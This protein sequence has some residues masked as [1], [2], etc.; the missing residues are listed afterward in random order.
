MKRETL[1]YLRVSLDLHWGFSVRKTIASKTRETFI[2]P[3]PTTFIGALAYGY[4]RLNHLPEEQD[5][6]SAGEIIRRK[7]LSVN[8]K[9]N[10]PMIHY[11][12]I[13]RIWWYKKRERIAKTDAVAIGKAYKGLKEA[14][15]EEPDIDAIYIFGNHVE[16][17][18]MKQLVLAAYSIVRLGGSHG[19]VSVRRVSEGVVEPLE[20]IRGKTGHS[21]WADLSRKP[22]S[23][24][25][26]RQ[27]VV[28]PVKNPIGS[29]ADAVC[30]EQVYPFRVDT[31]K[32]EE[33]EVEV[34]QSK[35]SFYKVEGEL[36]IAEQ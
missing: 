22:I 8:V 33:I 5:T 3:P 17:G 9:V 16:S 26:L 34:D 21:F 24:K 15:R 30:R 35:A 32:P 31:L 11:S 25:I 1:R 14:I 12:D 6:L 18:E 28:D 4:A 20:I 7:V 10:T 13:N 23:T 36:V 27:L 29:Y 19:L 2:I